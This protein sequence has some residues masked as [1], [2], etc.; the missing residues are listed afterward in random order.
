M[1]KPFLLLQSR[2]EDEASDDEYTAFLKFGELQP[3]QLLRLR[4]DAGQYPELDFAQYSGIIMGG[5]PAN[6][7]Y[8][9][10]HKPSSQRQFEE[11]VIPLIQRVIAEDKP[12]LGACLGIGAVVTALGSAPDFDHGEPVKA[13][14]ISK[15]PEAIG[16]PLLEG[17]AEQFYGFVG[18]KEGVAV[19]PPGCMVLARSDTCVQMLRVGHNVYATQFHPELDADGLALR[20][21]VYRHAGYFRPDEAES[22]IAEA[23]RQ[24]VVEPVKILHNF[25]QRYMC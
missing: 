15:T 23:Y 1:T 7:A 6:F 22:L 13:V 5:G 3:D 21:D 24:S 18:H 10:A 25:V 11:Y 8:D 16:D 2:P 14:W 4:L 19:A 20:I 17:V 9:K 12:F